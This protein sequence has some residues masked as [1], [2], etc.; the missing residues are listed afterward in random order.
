MVESAPR[1]GRSAEAFLSQVSVSLTVSLS[2]KS[3]C[4]S[5]EL[6]KGVGV[7]GTLVGVA[8]AGTASYNN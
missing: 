4:R 2:Q 6:G 7:L 8:K 1:C 5:R 3:V